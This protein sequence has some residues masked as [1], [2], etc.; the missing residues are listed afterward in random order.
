MQ[1]AFE[2]TTDAIDAGAVRSWSTEELKR[3]LLL[4]DP[5]D[6][7]NRKDF[8][9]SAIEPDHVKSVKYTGNV[10]ETSQ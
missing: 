4:F 6:P 3:F 10:I 9:L 1:Q 7:S 8:E 5:H 2:L